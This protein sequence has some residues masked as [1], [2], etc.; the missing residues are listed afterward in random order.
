VTLHLPIEEGMA[1]RTTLVAIAMLAIA[2]AGFV[3]LDP[4]PA[5]EIALDPANVPHRPANVPL[6]ASPGLNIISTDA[7]PPIPLAVN[8]SFVVELPGDVKNVLVGSPDIL[9]VVMRTSRRAYVSGVHEGQSNVFFFGE[10]NRTIG[11]LDVYVTN[12]APLAVPDLVTVLRYRHEDG[13]EI[14]YNYLRCN[15]DTCATLP[16]YVPPQTVPNTVINNNYAAPPP[17]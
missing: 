7:V 9:T 16:Y 14:E 6:R 11:L 1:L 3:S 10:G 13:K 8:K 5:T 17:K 12:R 15:L 2:M 4:A